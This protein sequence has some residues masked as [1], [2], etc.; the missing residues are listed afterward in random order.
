[1][2]TPLHLNKQPPLRYFTPSQNIEEQIEILNNLI[3]TAPP[4]SAR[5]YTITPALAEYIIKHRNGANRKP[6][7]AK[8]D[9]YIHAMETKR[10]P[11]TGST[12]VFSKGGFL[13]DGQH[14]LLACIRAQVPLTTFVVFNIP[15]SA[16]AMI[17]IGRKRSNVDAFQI[18]RVP[19]SSTAA[20]AARWIMIH[21]DN[22]LNRGR[23]WTNEELFKFYESK[24]NTASFHEFVSM[25]LDIEEAT[26][27]KAPGGKRRNYLPAGSLAAY[28][29]LFSKINR[30]GAAQFANQLLCNQR[31]GRAYINTIRER[32]D[33][34]AGRLHESVRN[35]LFVQA[36][37][38]FRQETRPSKAI[39]TW[40]LSGDFP[41]I[42]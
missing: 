1:M 24:L 41:E 7:T 15:D 29:V 17:D 40:N 23:T 33:A 30:K 35:A 19:N 16:F 31:H 26:K 2:T 13:L 39:F 28:L 5:V 22:P 6:N 32:M 14:R 38:G 36:W 10:W 21:E 25:A 11:V 20:A 8:I 27:E 37:N 9:E 12:I 34:N 18:A 42:I 4:D 3:E